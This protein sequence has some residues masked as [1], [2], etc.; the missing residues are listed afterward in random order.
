MITN[1]GIERSI[2]E[3]RSHIRRKT[4]GFMLSFALFWLMYLVI[5]AATAA[6]VLVALYNFPR[7]LMAGLG[8][9]IIFGALLF[10]SLSA[11][12]IVVRFLFARQ[13]ETEEGLIEIPAIEKDP[14]IAMINE[15]CD[16]VKAVRPSKI[17]LSHMPNASVSG[18]G[19]LQGIFRPNEKKLTIGYP[20]ILFLNRSEFR[21]VLAHEFAHFSKDSLVPGQFLSRLHKGVF[22][23]LYKKGS[24][25]EWIRDM[26][27][28]RG[29]PGLV[30]RLAATLSNFIR[31][32]FAQSLENLHLRFMAI[33]RLQE[34]SADKIAACVAGHKAIWGSLLKTGFLV[35]T[36]GQLDGQVVE[37]LDT[38]NKL[39]QHYWTIFS[40]LISFRLEHEGIA[41]PLQET[42][43]PRSEREKNI[44]RRLKTG[45]AWHAH[46]SDDDRK[47]NV[48][49][50]GAELWEDT[51]MFHSRTST[52]KRP[53]RISSTTNSVP[54]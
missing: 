1:P 53:K 54:P 42:T 15:I 18:Y 28:S 21:A 12:L 40:G 19:A 13:N 3:I 26:A 9:M 51:A 35:E 43:A 11:F 49:G 48:E 50:I 38:E 47:K 52:G 45:D 41:L 7:L 44:I 10:I 34:F 24:I 46:P 16:E 6:G 36:I 39:P 8:G 20:L 31:K 29:I 27:H 32:L 5:L 14:F 17:L 37:N 22:T 33:S 2:E 23:M 25:D 4:F 30:G